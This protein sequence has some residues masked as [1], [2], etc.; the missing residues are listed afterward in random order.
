LVSCPCD[1]LGGW[2]LSARFGFFQ[3][4]TKFSIFSFLSFLLLTLSAG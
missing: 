1:T 2:C 3:E 4:L